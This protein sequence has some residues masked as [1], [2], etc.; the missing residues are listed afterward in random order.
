MIPIAMDNLQ[1]LF[2]FNTPPPKKTTWILKRL[3]NADNL[4]KMEEDLLKNTCS[5]DTS[6]IQGKEN[7][8]LG[9]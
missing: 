2:Y 6:T 1:E 3:K 4:E 8:C 7:P 9:S 5:F